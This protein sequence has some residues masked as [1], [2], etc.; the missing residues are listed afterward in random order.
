MNSYAN[1]HSSQIRT[2]DAQES[3]V[4]NTRNRRMNSVS[5]LQRTDGQ[6]KQSLKKVEFYDRMR[7]SLNDARLKWDHTQQSL[8]PT[9]SINQAT[10]SLIQVAFK[11][12]ESINNSQMHSQNSNKQLNQSIRSALSHSYLNYHNYGRKLQFPEPYKAFNYQDNSLENQTIRMRRQERSMLKQRQI[13]IK[14]ERDQAL[15]EWLAN[16]KKSIIRD[17]NFQD[18]FQMFQKLKQKAEN[19]KSEIAALVIQKAYRMLVIRKQYLRIRKLREKAAIRLQK[20]WRRKKVEIQLKKLRYGLLNK[21][22][23]TVKKYIKGYLIFKRVKLVKN[24]IREKF[25]ETYFQ[26]KRMELYTDSQIKIRYYFLKYIDELRKKQ[27]EEEFKQYMLGQIEFEQSTKISEYQN[28][29]LKS[30]SLK[31]PKKHCC[32]T[33]SQ[34]QKEFSIN[35]SKKNKLSFLTT[36]KSVKHSFNQS[37]STLNRFK[38][39]QQI[40]QTTADRRLQPTYDITDNFNLEINQGAIHD[41][42]TTKFVL[43]P[44]NE[45]ASLNEGG[46]SIAMSRKHIQPQLRQIQTIASSNGMITSQNSI[47]SISNSNNKQTT[48]I[49]LRQKRKVKSLNMLQMDDYVMALNMHHQF[50]TNASLVRVLDATEEERDGY[51]QYLEQCKKQKCREMGYVDYLLRVRQQQGDLERIR[52]S[53]LDFVSKQMQVKHICSKIYFR[54]EH[55]QSRSFHQQ[56]NQINGKVNRQRVKSQNMDRRPMV[57]SIVK[58]SFQSINQKFQ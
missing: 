10:H 1:G 26:R 21:A 27:L 50:Y 46:G 15:K 51:Q 9:E 23:N 33:N 30:T 40:Y 58:N 47:I 24:R 6:N 52:R 39:S 55:G 4:L 43:S 2:S 44:P 13:Q 38:E 54:D 3:L 36:N 35:R 57:H 19:A 56:Q 17:L 48:S 42:L 45:L 28:T 22:A 37:I 29:Q 20:C 53:H 31:R 18:E 11:N 5:K 14:R 41:N 16:D 25:M 7:F 12:R 32:L 8:A 34:S 49:E